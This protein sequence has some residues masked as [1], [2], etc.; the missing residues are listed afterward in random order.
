MLLK[1][2]GWNRLLVIGRGVI[3]TLLKRDCHFIRDLLL[4]LESTNGVFVIIVFL[5]CENSLF[6][7]RRSPSLYYWLFGYPF[8]NTSVLLQTFI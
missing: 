4:N 6:M 1:R 5:I 8:R 3:T 7:I 2:L